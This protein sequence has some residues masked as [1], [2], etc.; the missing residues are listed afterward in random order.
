MTVVELVE[1]DI[2]R[3]QT[4]AIV[5]AANSSLLGGGG[6]DGA[7]HQAGGPAILDECRRVRA[8]RYPA[9]LPTGRAVV[10]GAGALR[11]KWVIHTVG[12]VYSHSADPPRE[13]AACYAASL[14]EADEVGARSVSF[15]AISTGIFGYPMYEAARV[16]LRTVRSAGANVERARFVLF[17]ARSHAVFTD[18]MRLLERAESKSTV[19]LEC[20]TRTSQ[21]VQ[22]FPEARSRI[23]LVRRFDGEE[24][25]RLAL[26]LLPMQME[27][28]WLIYLDDE[29]LYFHRSWTGV[30]VYAVKL[31]GV[32]DGAEVVEAWVNRKPGEWKTGNDHEDAS[33]LSFLVE[34]L[35]MGRHVDFPG[36]PGGR[37]NSVVAHHLV[38]YARAN[39]ES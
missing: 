36:L 3:E 35:L 26:G 32:G 25:S 10:T 39:D 17:D 16:A 28:K 33:L 31:R 37:A 24:R 2:T 19:V 8:E 6:V 23:A 7:I 29:W 38:G 20:A 27:D 9:G 5:N 1:G 21:P 13:L 4:D 22:P 11:A 18:A 15:P 12:P 30:C 14:A 34:R